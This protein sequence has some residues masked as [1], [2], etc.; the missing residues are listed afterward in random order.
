[1]DFFLYNSAGYLA[2]SNV[3]GAYCN[4]PTGLG[5]GVAFN[6]GLFADGTFTVLIVP[7]SQI[8]GTYSVQF[9][10][11]PGGDTGPFLP[12]NGGMTTL[13]LTADRPSAYAWFW[14]PSGGGAAAITDTTAVPNCNGDTVPVVLVFWGPYNSISMVEK[15]RCN[16][17]AETAYMMGSTAAPGGYNVQ[18]IHWPGLSGSVTLQMISG[19]AI[20]PAPVN[21][22]AVSVVT[23]QPGE[24]AVLSFTTATANKVLSGTCS[25]NSGVSN[26]AGYGIYDSTGYPVRMTL[27]GG[28]GTPSD[29]F[30]PTVPL[31]TAGTYYLVINPENTVDALWTFQMTAT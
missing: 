16:G 18:V 26:E 15:A 13:G 1:V 24:S 2:A 29:L 21:G 22:T 10:G 9:F 31:P 5:A 20:T 25:N 28:C 4:G 7:A 12:S 30:T 27:F 14:Q 11:T 19:S 3:G 8:Y 17:Y 23:T 6:P